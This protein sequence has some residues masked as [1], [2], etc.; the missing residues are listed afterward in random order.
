MFREYDLM[1]VS[2]VDSL[3]ACVNPRKTGDGPAI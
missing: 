2:E 3:V 1:L